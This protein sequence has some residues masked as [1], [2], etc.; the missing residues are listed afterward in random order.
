MSL[1]LESF[2]F[3]VLVLDRV[4]LDNTEHIV[5]L[6]V[7]GLQTTEDTVVLD[8]VGLETTEDAVTMGAW[9]LSDKDIL[10]FGVTPDAGLEEKLGK[11][12]ASANISLTLL[13]LVS[14]S[15]P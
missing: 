7:V 2:N 9:K 3:T 8:A 4:G 10:V 5:T 14:I 11:P 1:L 6:D 13:L 15:R 12:D